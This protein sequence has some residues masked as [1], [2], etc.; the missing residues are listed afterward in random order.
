MKNCVQIALV[1]AQLLLVYTA[2][3]QDIECTGCTTNL[4]VCSGTSVC[5][6]LD[7]TGGTPPYTYTFSSNVSPGSGTAN[8]CSFD[9]SGNAQNADWSVEVEDDDGNTE[10]FEINL[11][12][13]DPDADFD[14]PVLACSADCV[15]MTSTSSCI[16]CTDYAWT[17]NGVPVPSADDQTN[18]CLDLTSAGS[19]TADIDVGLTITTAAGCSS[20]IVQ[21]V[22]V[23][24]APFLNLA[25]LPSF[26]QCNGAATFDL[27]VTELVGADMGDYQITWDVDDGT[28]VWNSDTPPSG[29]TYVYPPGIY[30]LEYCVTGTNGCAMCDTYQV[31]NLPNPNMAFNVCEDAPVSGCAPFEVCLAVSNTS[32]NPTETNYFLDIGG[33]GQIDITS[34]IQDCVGTPCIINYT[35]PTS[36][37][38]GTGDASVTATMIA[39]LPNGACVE[40]EQSQVFEVAAPP[41]AAISS[42]AEICLGE[43]T[44][45]FNNSTPGTGLNC[46]APNQYTWFVDGVQVGVEFALSNYSTTFLTEGTH[47]VELCIDDFTCEESCHLIEICVTP[48]PTPLYDAPTLL[49]TGDPYQADNLSVLE[50]CSDAWQWTITQSGAACDVG[51]TDYTFQN[52]TSTSTEDLELVFNVAGTYTIA[53]DIIQTY[54]PRYCGSV[55]RATNTKSN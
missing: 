54:R 29:E 17:V 16:G 48:P 37:C 45:V 33:S 10:T 1:L 38:T 5:D 25:G 47:T 15:T 13:Q 20:T 40:N 6:A 11:T 26:E 21:T 49:C 19:G 42:E 28:D 27:V 24:Q 22:E 34:D 3:A 36:T 50:L 12:V 52:G 32:G 7:I 9:F 55:E 41:A 4:T 14:F 39:A 18:P 43:S 30:T 8:L 53:L 51:A 35:L 46:A 23:A 2:A 31:T 44:T